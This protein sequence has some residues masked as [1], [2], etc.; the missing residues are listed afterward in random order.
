MFYIYHIDGVKVGCTKNPAKRIKS[1]QGYS[2][3]EILDKTKDIDVASRLEFF[4]QDKLGYKRDKRSYKETINNF[5][6]K[7][8][9]H[10]TDKTITFKGSI[11]SNLSTVIIP[12]VIELKDGTILS[13]EKKHKEFILKNNFKSQHSSERY[14]YIK[15]LLLEFDDSTKEVNIYDNIRQWA[16][17]RG[18]YEKGNSH[19]QYVKLMEES[20]ELAKALL[21][22]DTPEIIDAIGDMVVVLTNLAKI[23]GH[24]I[25]D[26]IDSAY[27]EIKNRQGEMIGGT[28]VKNS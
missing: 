7:T 13:L 4:W 27:N 3:Y 17:E 23:E 15:R 20:G 18:I 6:P 24:N 10:I 5:K 11:D 19:T 25:E 12:D 8:M 21:T 28:F 16:K 26:C 1:E 9:L 2:K 14:V 22:N